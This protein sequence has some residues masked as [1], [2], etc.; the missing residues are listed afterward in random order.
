VTIL[1]IAGVRLRVFLPLRQRVL[2]AGPHGSP[3]L[4]DEDHT[5]MWIFHTEYDL[6]PAELGELATLAVVER[7]GE[8]L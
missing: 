7:L 5:R 8:I 4:P 6:A 2:P 3:A 1:P